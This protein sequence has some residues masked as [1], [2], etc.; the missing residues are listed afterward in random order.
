MPNLSKAI[1]K[2]STNSIDGIDDLLKLEDNLLNISEN[3]PKDAKKLV[4]YDANTILVDLLAGYIDY[5]DRYLPEKEKPGISHP[6]GYIL[7]TKDGYNISLYGKNLWY[8]EFGTGDQGANSK[9]RQPKMMSRRG[10]VYNAGPKVI[11]ANTYNPES[12]IDNPDVPET[13]KRIVNKHPG[14]AKHNWWM[15]PYGLSN[16]IPA[17][18]I[19]YNTWSNYRDELE[20]D[21]S[22]S[23]RLTKNNLTYVLRNDLLKGLKGK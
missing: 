2:I 17:G 8:Y 23:A 13:Y 18:S 21:S 12:S 9:Y 1:N 4:E 14:M 7:E 10:Y 22:S 20:S 6:V 16:G 3:L 11:R 15:S 19:L 5:T